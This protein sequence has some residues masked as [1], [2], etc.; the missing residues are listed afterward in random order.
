MIYSA[1]VDLALAG[2]LSLYGPKQASNRWAVLFFVFVGLG[3]L[4][5]AV[6]YSDLRSFF[7]FLLQAC[8]PY[9]FAM[10]AIAYSDKMTR[11][12][13]KV[14]AYALILPPVITLFI[15]PLRPEIRFDFVLM[16]LWAAPY[17]LGGCFLLVY[18]YIGEKDRVKR[19]YRLLAMC[20][21]VP[22][23]IA[24][25]VF[26]RINR[27]VNQHFDGYLSITIVAWCGFAFF[28][29]A[30]IRFGILGVR[31]KFEKQL[32]DQKIKGIATGAAMYNHAM[33]NRIINIDML[34]GRVKEW[35]ES[36]RNEQINND[37]ERIMAE[38]QQ[39]MHMV[40]RI[41]KQIEDVELEE[42]PANAIDMMKLALHSNR[43]L[44]EGKSFT[45]TTEYSVIGD[46]TCDKLHLQE[47]FNNLIIN[48]VDAAENEGGSLAIGIH[49]SKGGIRIDFAD[50]GKGMS[51]EAATRI[52][53]PFYST[54]QR[55][56]NFG[57]GLSYCRMIMRKHGGSIK[58]V[59][60]PGEGTIFTLRFPKYR[61]L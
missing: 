53:D 41:Q 25:V 18:S 47:V 11:R 51:K 10:F 46:M 9:G 57:L 39:V 56:E 31:I 2:F 12:V 17:Y 45:V 21:F 6:T 50:N 37:I 1:V 5:D 30:A 8:A 13:Q 44:L 3:S 16:L 49:E 28:L 61:K 60:H 26:D 48:A 36:Q 42:E 19:K 43:H 7:F 22:P 34:T 29:V 58:A 38:T 54:K 4:S 23:I 20:F 32:H 33:K 27:A 52:F 40:K 35:V 24:I 59:S 55:E 15:S 14:L